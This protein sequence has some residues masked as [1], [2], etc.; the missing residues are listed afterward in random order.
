MS[1]TSNGLSVYINK[2]YNLQSSKT[3]ENWSVHRS[4]DFRKMFLSLNNTHS[5]NIAKKV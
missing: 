5:H 1:T 3:V 4:Y 2:Y